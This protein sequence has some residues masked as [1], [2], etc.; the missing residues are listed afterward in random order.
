MHTTAMSNANVDCPECIE[1]KVE[2]ARQQEATTGDGLRLGDCS[3][4]YKKWV[5]CLEQSNGQAKACAAV[6]KD[7]KECHAE[8]QRAKK[9]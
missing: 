5:D 6:M 4:S 3:A 9:Q 8:Q 1:S 2:A 7:F